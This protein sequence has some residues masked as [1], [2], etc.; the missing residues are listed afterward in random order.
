MIFHQ[1]DLLI[2]M[3][4]QKSSFIARFKTQSNPVHQ[5]LLESANLVESELN[6]LRLKYNESME[7]HEK[8]KS[9]NQE[10]LR[11]SANRG[12]GNKRTGFGSFCT[13]HF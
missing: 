13:G 5:N 2:K 4:G 8:V 12:Y 10:L 9:E 1:N 6:Q 7:D 11:H 3:F